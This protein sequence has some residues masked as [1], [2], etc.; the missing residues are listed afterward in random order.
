MSAERRLTYSQAIH[1]ALAQ[2]MARDPAVFVMGQGVDDFKGCYG[3]TRDLARDFPGRC[4]DTPLSEEGMTGVAIGAAMVGM[5]P[6]HTH[7]RMDFVLLA[8]NQLLNIAAKARYMYGGAVSVPLVVRGVIGRSWGQG[9]Q[10][11]QACYPIFMHTPGIKVVA[12]TTPYD[13]KGLMIQAIRDDDPVLFV[14][15]RMLH[16]QRGH[17]PE[18]SFAVPFGRARVLAEGHHLTLVAISHMAVEAMRAAA[19]LAAQGISAEVIDPVT[20]APL[21]LDTIVASARRTGHLLVVDHDWTFAGAAAEVIA[22]VVERL[23]AEAGAVRMQRMG[24]APVTCPT[25]PNLERLFYPN[26]QSIAAAAFSLVGGGGSW[27]PEWMDAP[28]IVEFKGPF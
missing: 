15:H 26:P 24:L 8:V 9:A 17:V 16:F 11:S 13:A 18:E 21:D 5:R 27:T 7:I 23:G 14:E 2:E 6:V 19:L 10:H 25:A 22:G 28:E 20:L 1:E 12:P 3:T 4:F